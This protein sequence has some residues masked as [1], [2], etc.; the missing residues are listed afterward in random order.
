MC[1]LVHR[2]IPHLTWRHN[3]LGLLQ[4][5]VEEG[6]TEELR[7]HVWHPSLRRDGIE[8]SGLLHDHRFNLTSHVLVGAI[9]QVEYTLFLPEPFS[10]I[11]GDWQLHTVVP[12]RKALALSGT[13]DGLVKALPE[14]YIAKTLDV[15]VKA[16]ERY[17]FPKFKFHG[18]YCQSDLVVTVVRKSEQEDA[19][20]KILAPYGKPVVHAFAD[21][22]PEKE[23]EGPLIEAQRALRCAWAGERP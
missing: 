6:E 3:G 20:A 12:A 4:S 16:G 18:T 23:W 22:F 13:N 1:G 2:L 5:Y 8:D 15:P 9:R 21:P 11:D 19:Q 17:W 7:V 14:R 10:H